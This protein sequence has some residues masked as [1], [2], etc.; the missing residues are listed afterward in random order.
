VLALRNLLLTIL[1]VQELC[2]ALSIRADFPFSIPS[3]TLCDCPALLLQVLSIQPSPQLDVASTPKATLLFLS[4]FLRKGKAT[5]AI[6]LA[7][8]PIAY[9]G[10]LLNVAPYMLSFLR[11]I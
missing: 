3:C 2:P 8:L 1:N 6:S 7:A 11:D 5:P 9:V 10:R 4:V